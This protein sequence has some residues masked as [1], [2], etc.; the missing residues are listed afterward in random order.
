MAREPVQTKF[1]PVKIGLEGRFSDLIIFSSDVEECFTSGF[2]SPIGADEPFRQT[3][4]NATS[5][6]D[7]ECHHAYEYY[8]KF[9]PEEIFCLKVLPGEG[10]SNST[11]LTHGSPKIWKPNIKRIGNSSFTRPEPR[12]Y[13]TGVIALVPRK[14]RGQCGLN[15]TYLVL[16]IWSGI[17]WIK[18]NMIS[19]I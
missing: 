4:L 17:D 2:N 18:R 16:N 6:N 15:T 9:H 19:V 3:F 8:Y 11:C 1:Y 14:E 5:R 13:A 10:V 12:Y 7:A